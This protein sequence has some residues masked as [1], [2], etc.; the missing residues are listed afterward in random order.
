MFSLSVYSLKQC[1]SLNQRL[2]LPVLIGM[3][4]QWAPGIHSSPCPS[5]RGHRHTQPY[6][7][8]YLNAGGCEFK[9]SPLH[10][11]CSFS[12]SYT[13]LSESIFY[14][15]IFISWSETILWVVSAPWCGTDREGVA[16]PLSFSRSWTECRE[17]GW[18]AW[19]DVQ[20]CPHKLKEW[21]IEFSST[22]F[23]SS[24]IIS[25]CIYK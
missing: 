7:D 16:C 20:L 18:G 25:Y 13:L 23:S 22:F 3:A 5:I 1:L 12:L 19:L 24:N 4:A 8:F 6:L 10:S 2:A 21:F 17:H 11:R 15:L 14:T 9:F